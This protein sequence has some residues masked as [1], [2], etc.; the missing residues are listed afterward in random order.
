MGIG[1][2]IQRRAE[3]V[4]EATE[5]MDRQ[6]MEATEPKKEKTAADKQQSRG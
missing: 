6:I 5:E 4:Q 3:K 1:E 2:R